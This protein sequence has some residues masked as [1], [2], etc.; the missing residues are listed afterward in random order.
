MRG[1]F[2]DLRSAESLFSSGRERPLILVIDDDQDSRESLGDLLSM[3]Y[4]VLLASDGEAGLRMA[5]DERPDLVLTDVYM[6]K[7]DGISALEELLRDPRTE[8]I[9]VIFLSVQTDELAVR[10]LEMG[11]VDYLAKPANGRELVARIDRALRQSEERQ[12]LRKQAQTDGLTGLPNFRALSGRLEEEVKRAVRYGY[13]L[14]LVMLDLDHLKAINDRFGHDVGNQ[15]ITALSKHLRA[16]LR[17]TDFAAR[18]GGD[19]FVVL[20]PYQT[21][22]EAAVFVERLR[23]GLDP[24]GR[25]LIS[26]AVSANVRLTLSA[27][28]ANHWAGAPMPSAQVLMHAADAALYEAKR[29]GRDCVVLYSGE[30]DGSQQEQAGHA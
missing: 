14:S 9:P 18:Y 27:G 10:C 30:I 2:R 21:A 1:N 4:D 16:N 24:V 25:L 26:D 12:I 6:P 28:V 8:E 13:P 17:E 11:A 19:E 3:H 15:A 5:R 22:S 7:L 23:A 20:L 29:R